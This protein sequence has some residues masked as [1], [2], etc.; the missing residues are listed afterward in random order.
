MKNMEAP[1]TRTR[2]ELVAQLR[3]ALGTLLACTLLTGVLYPLAVT[4][5]AQL[6]FPAQA[7]GS[8]L[9]GS[10]G[11]MRGSRL[12]GQSFS[13]PRYF[14]GRPSAT[15]PQP[16]NGAASG[17]SNLGPLNPAL[18]DAVKS[19]VAALRSA[20]PGNDAPVP[21]DL[22]TASGSGLDPQ[23]SVAAASYQAARVARLR[24]LPLA[25]VQALIGRHTEGR[26]LG[27]VGEPR[28]N[29]LELNLALDALK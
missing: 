8:L 26:L 6:A 9:T 12:I 14:W 3:P 5:L 20:D 2:R 1:L 15:T 13:A 29:V 17:A 19:R 21:V 10:D 24:G 7:G 28:V 4:A 23:I 27:V 22:V 25:R 11:Q 16:Y 18:L